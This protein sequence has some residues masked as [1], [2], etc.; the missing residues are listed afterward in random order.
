MNIQY[1]ST[2]RDEE[3]GTAV[4]L[5]FCSI[6]KSINLLLKGLSQEIDLKNLNKI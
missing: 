2:A 1:S 3:G 4:R 6:E 5:V